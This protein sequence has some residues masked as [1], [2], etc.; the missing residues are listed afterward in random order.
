M[1]GGLQS[2]TS[3]SSLTTGFTS[4][5]DENRP[6]VIRSHTIAQTGTY[7]PVSASRQNDG[8]AYTRQEMLA[9]F[10]KQK[11]EGGLNTDLDQLYLKGW[12]PENFPEGISA[13]SWQNPLSTDPL[14]KQATVGADVCWDSTGS[15][16]PLGLVGLTEDEK[17]V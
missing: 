17:E 1:N 10:E 7:V 3:F 11:R 13:P 8:T 12:D 5:R 6:T 14:Q 2:H 16:L 9:L 15:S 4:H